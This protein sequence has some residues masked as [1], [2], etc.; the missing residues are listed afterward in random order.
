MLGL[1]ANPNEPGKTVPCTGTKCSAPSAAFHFPG[2][3][4]LHLQIQAVSRVN[5]SFR[6]F[7]LSKPLEY[8]RSFE[9]GVYHQP[10]RG[11]GSLDYDMTGGWSG[12]SGGTKPQGAITSCDG[13]NGP[14]CSQRLYFY[15]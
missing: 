15:Q 13:R 10:A 11:G 1:E 6:C 5:L 14:H 3:E 2:A 4:R 9:A 12:S 7:A 8:E